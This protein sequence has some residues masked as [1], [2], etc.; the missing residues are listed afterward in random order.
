MSE[1]L[2]VDALETLVDVYLDWVR[3]ERGLAA[4]TVSAYQRDLADFIGYCSQSEQSEQVMMIRGWLAY[5]ESN[6]LSARSQARG[7]VSLRGFFGFLVAENY[8]TENPTIHLD[9]P[10]I[11]K[12]LPHTLSLNEVERLLQ[13]PSLSSPRGVR[14]RT[15]LELLYATGLRV[16]EL[17]S[18]KVDNLHLE[19]GYIRVVGKGNKERIVPLGE[20]A[21]QWI[22][23]YVQSDR[24]LLSKK[25]T[26]KGSG[27][28]FLTRLGRP[29]TR[30]GFH[31]NLA[32]ITRRAGIETRVSPHIL[33]HAFA[34]HLLERGAD[35]RSL[36]LMLG[37]ADI[38]TTEIYTHVSKQRLAALHRQHHPRG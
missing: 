15:M 19:Q 21:R 35:L 2:T 33:R 27:Y 7:L 25:S 14:D 34:T 5:R 29:M 16:S 8:Q 22:E 11:G 1:R 30:Q 23:T 26:L 32:S 24:L 38:S 31:K 12:T 4:N 20:T 17:V 28:L 37:H 6:G 18:I 3:L 13:T 10:K 36:Q 9:L